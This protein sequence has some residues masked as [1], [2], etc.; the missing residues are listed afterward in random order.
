[1]TRLSFYERNGKLVGFA[2]RGHSGYAEAGQDIVCAAVSCAAAIAITA[3]KDVAGCSSS[4]EL[5]E[6]RACISFTIIGEQAED[7]A[8]V[9]ESVLRAMYMQLSQY[10][11]SYGSY[12]KVKLLK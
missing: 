4:V 1:M 6:E 9:C 7:K 3:I 8:L 11:E 12:L 10:A 2:S 5:D